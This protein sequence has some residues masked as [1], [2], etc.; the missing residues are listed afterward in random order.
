[1]PPRNTRMPVGA[2]WGRWRRALVALPFGCRWCDELLRRADRLAFSDA[3]LPFQ[4]ISRVQSA[5][6]VRAAAGATTRAAVPAGAAETRAAKAGKTSIT[7][8]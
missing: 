6:T 3:C 4:K 2:R 5:G 1:M 8:R 7:F